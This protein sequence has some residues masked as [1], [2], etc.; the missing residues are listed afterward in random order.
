MN[1]RKSVNKSRLFLRRKY[2]RLVSRMPERT[3]Y[4][5]WTL[6]DSEQ[7]LQELDNLLNQRILTKGNNE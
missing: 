3:I 1:K 6:H 5:N 2:K 4:V 7:A